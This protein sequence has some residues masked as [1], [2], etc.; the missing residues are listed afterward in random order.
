VF[1]PDGGRVATASYDK[2]A[3]LWDATTGRELML[4]GGHADR[5]TTAEFSPDGGRVTTASYDKTARVWDARTA[6]LKVQIAWAEA[7]QFDPLSSSERFELG[8]PA[9]GDI[10]EW[11]GDES[12]CDTSA[13]APYD[14]DRRA[15]GI[16]L[17]QIVT[18]VAAGHCA[19]G[20][21]GISRD[22]RAIYQHG[23]ALMASCDMSGARKDFE[24]ALG[25]GYR[26]AQIDLAMSLLQPDPT[27]PDAAAEPDLSRAIELLARAWRSGI[28]IAAFELGDLYEHGA[29]RA[30][31]GTAY[32]APD[33]ARAWFWY[34]Q[35]ADAGEPNALARFAE[36]ADAAAFSAASLADSTALSL[37]AFRYYA[38][39]AERARSEDWP[40]EAWRNWRYRRAS[41]ARLLARAGMMPQVADAY[42]SVLERYAPRRSS[43]WARLAALK[44][45]IAAGARSSR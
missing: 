22:A 16:M 9:P 32:L 30:S 5:V 37:E 41:L 29:G 26:S 42:E 6:S 8:L 12:A 27:R 35:G 15:P 3:R 33:V 14:P 11:V 2:T 40:D 24:D 20:E 19:V 45:S 39:A 21:R 38:A 17:A 1:S 13:A 7:A 44:G 10:R 43:I 36:K 28:S 23:R 4:L 34:R 31:S 25:R 18:D